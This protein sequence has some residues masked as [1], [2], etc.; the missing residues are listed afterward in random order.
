MKIL[1]TLR[2]HK[3]TIVFG[4]LSVVFGIILHE[5]LS[6]KMI[7][8]K[9]DNIIFVVDEFRLIAILLYLF[10]YIFVVTFSIPAASMLTIFSGY[11]FGWIIGGFVA[12]SGAVMGSS[13]LF[14]IVQA[15]LRPT[16][17]EKLK[18]NS[19]FEDI[20]NGIL[21]NQVRYLLF[22]RF[23]PIFPFWLVNLAP[24]ILGVRFRI[25]FLTTSLGI[26]PGTFIIAGIGQKLRLISEPSLD[27]VNELTSDPQFILLFLALSFIIIL[28]ILWRWVQFKRGRS[29]ELN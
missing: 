26:F 22:L 12:L 11:L 3:T 28:P 21:K 7:V 24:A 25:F 6:F 4:I 8:S 5:H 29:K 14:L 17:D 10:V 2:A 9:I 13:I 18:S 23:M 1:P 20:S 19:L 15:G 27:F 16:I